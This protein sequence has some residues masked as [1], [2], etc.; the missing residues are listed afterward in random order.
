MSKEIVESDIN[1]VEVEYGPDNS[2]AAQNL[3]AAAE[4]LDL[5]PILIK[6][7]T[8]GVFLVPE[9]VAA[10]AE[11]YTGRDDDAP[12]V[13]AQKNL[14]DMTAGELDKVAEDEGIDLTGAKQSK[15][16]RVGRIQEK[17]AEKLAAEQAKPAPTDD[18]ATTDG[19]DDEPAETQE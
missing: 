14:T 6:T 8:R 18:A 19:D 5:N 3:L 7:T 12:E 16:T 1:W 4:R 13:N 15:A 17:R 10:E 9:E 11:D 2:V